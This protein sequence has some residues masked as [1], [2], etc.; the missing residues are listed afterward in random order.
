MKK[1][2]KAQRIECSV[3]KAKIIPKKEETIEQIGKYLGEV[4][5]DRYDVMDCPVCGCQIKLGERIVDQRKE[6]L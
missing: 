5:V 2:D 6:S 3:C 1:K 4:F